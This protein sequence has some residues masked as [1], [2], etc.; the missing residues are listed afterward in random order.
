MSYNPIYFRVFLS[1]SNVI[2]TTYFIIKSDNFLLVLIWTHWY[3]FIIYH[4]QLEILMN[5]EF[6]YEIVYASHYDTYMIC[7][8][9]E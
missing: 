1:W 3:H 7:W 6:F 8:Q 9:F 5:C 4:L 2:D